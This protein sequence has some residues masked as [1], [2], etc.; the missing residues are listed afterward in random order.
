MQEMM[1]E[2][3]AWA[4]AKGM[5]DGRAPWEVPTQAGSVL[6]SSETPEAKDRINYLDTLIEQLQGESDVVDVEQRRVHARARN[7]V[8]HAIQ[9][10][11]HNA[12]PPPDAA[13]H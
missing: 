2:I 12:T 13:L 9:E 10:Q 11:P 5:F 4:K 3:N 1:D 6:I 8:A 7:A